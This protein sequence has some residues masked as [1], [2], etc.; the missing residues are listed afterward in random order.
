MADQTMAGFYFPDSSPTHGSGAARLSAGPLSSRMFSIACVVALHL[1]VGS[2]IVMQH[3]E[4]PFL[5]EE[6]LHVSLVEEVVEPPPPPPPPPPPTLQMT[7]PPA[8]Q[9]AMPVIP[10]PV[11]VPPNA[12]PMAATPQPPVETIQGPPVPPPPPVKAVAGPP[13][14]Y[15]ATLVMTLQRAKQYPLAARKQRQEGVAYVRFVMNRAGNILSVKLE[16]SSGFPLLDEEAVALFGRV[17]ALP[18]LPAELPD[19][20]EMVIPIDFSMSQGGRHRH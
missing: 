10:V 7:P 6:P 20:M 15:A 4:V 13:P 5:P 9:L 2:L 18:P 19:P 16:R 3:R 11:V 8:P 17:S 14:D 1:A 12:R